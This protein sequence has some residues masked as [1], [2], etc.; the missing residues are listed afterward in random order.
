MTNPQVQMREIAGL[1]R[2]VAELR[3]QFRL[4]HEE[5]V[6]VL[7]QRRWRLYAVGAACSLALHICLMIYLGMVRHG[8]GHGNSQ[9]GGSS[10]ETAILN[11]EELTTEDPGEFDQLT[12]GPVEFDEAQAPSELS[13]INPENGIS[14]AS[15]SQ[16]PT[17][18]ASGDGTGGVPGFG[19][20][21]G[22]GG[23]GLGGGGATSFFGI[24]A[25]GTRFA[26]IVDV[27]GSMGQN[28]KLQMAMHELAKSVDALPDFS[29]F[30]VLLFSSS[31]IQ[32]PMQKGWM[33]ARKGTV[34]QFIAWLNRVDPGGGTEPRTS[35]FQV[36]SLDVRPDVIYFLTDGQF[37]DIVPDEINELNKRGKKVVI[38]T[39]QFGDPSGE[40]VM[41]EIARDS[42]GIY[43][44]VP[45]EAP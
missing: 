26:Y 16:M 12:A 11:I 35:F 42:G 9:D 25:K 36:L 39:I 28:R 43:R 3:E 41:R 7:N 44:F 21:E 22:G 30:Y 5:R 19:N 15:P 31:F 8:G 37:Q 27:S 38:N 23:L 2:S 6:R 10:F 34:R 18:G 24:G 40:D 4:M 32:P 33:P 14:T 13:A 20:G 45:A 1:R 29:H 17:L